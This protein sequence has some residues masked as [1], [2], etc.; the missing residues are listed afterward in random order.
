MP[1]EAYRCTQRFKG[2]TEAH[3]SPQR[4]TEATRVN[5]RLNQASHGPAAEGLAE[6]M[7]VLW[8]KINQN[9]SISL[10]CTVFCCWLVA[11]H[12]YRAVKL[13][14]PRGKTLYRAVKLLNLDPPTKH[15]IYPKGPRHIQIY[16]YIYI[17][18]YLSM[19][20]SMS[21][22]TYTHT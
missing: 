14:C 16:I 11:K 17:Y 12:V 2:L 13:Q 9:Q 6:L 1:T 8:T 3:R 21:L 22:Y 7:L 4:P 5:K 20:M 19:S 10:P 18:I 15:H